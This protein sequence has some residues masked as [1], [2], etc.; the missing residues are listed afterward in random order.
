MLLHQILQSAVMTSRLI[1]FWNNSDNTLL[2]VMISL[3][4]PKSN[5]ATIAQNMDLIN[6]CDES[7]AGINL[8]IM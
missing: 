7:G 6:S 5:E 2:Q 4:I 8:G 1:E 3:H